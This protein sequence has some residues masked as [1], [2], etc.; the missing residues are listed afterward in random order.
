MLNLGEVCA[1]G[2]GVGMSSF[3]SVCITLGGIADS[4]VPFCWM[5]TGTVESTGVD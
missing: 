2:G 5:G 1:A 3:I 4:G